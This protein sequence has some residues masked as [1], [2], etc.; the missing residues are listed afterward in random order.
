MLR[1]ANQ[2]PRPLEAMPRHGVEALVAVEALWELEVLRAL[3]GLWVL[4]ALVGLGGLGALEVLEVL[5]VDVAFSALVVLGALQ[6]LEEIAVVEA[7]VLL[8]TPQSPEVQRCREV[9]QWLGCPRCVSRHRLLLVVDPML[10]GAIPRVLTRF[11]EQDSTELAQQLRSAPAPRAPRASKGSAPSSR[12][13]GSGPPG[14]EAVAASVPGRLRRCLARIPPPAS[15][16]RCLA[17]PLPLGANLGTSDPSG[18]TPLPAP[19]DPGRPEG[20]ASVKALG[21]KALEARLPFAIVVQG[22]SA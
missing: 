3:G 16:L 14:E 19:A 6:A 17:S 4:G 20:R 10:S 7:L 9:R 2:A 8:G 22:A 21:P 13:R 1:P 15:S 11:P 5:E 12:L 18:S